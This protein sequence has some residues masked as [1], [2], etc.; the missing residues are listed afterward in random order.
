ME[1]K[2]FFNAIVEM[3]ETYIGGKPRKNNDDD[4]DVLRQTSEAVAQ[5]KHLS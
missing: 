2:E 3:D 4:D 1:S 5:R